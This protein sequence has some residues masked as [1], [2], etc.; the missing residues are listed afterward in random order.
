MAGRSGV[1]LLLHK[2]GMRVLMATDGSPRATATLTAVGRMLSPANR[3]VDSVTVVPRV[4][5][6]AHHSHRERL[7]RRA[8]FIADRTQAELAAEGVSVDASVRTGS[9]VRILIGASYNYDV[10][11]LA[12]TSRRSGPMAGLGPVASRVAE[13]AP[14]AVLLARRPSGVRT[15]G[16]GRRRW[17]RGFAASVGFAGGIS[18]RQASSARIP[19]FSNA[20]SVRSVKWSICPQ[21]MR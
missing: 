14:G 17:I 3:R 1:A 10:T 20:S 7:Y 8:Q 4:P 18:D 5:D 16:S 6:H 15:A 12:A 9:P 21:R 2:G 19:P 11:I 13:H